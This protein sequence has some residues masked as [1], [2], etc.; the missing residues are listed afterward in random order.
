MAVSVAGL[1][2][3]VMRAAKVLLDQ[4][5]N[6][7]TPRIPFTFACSIRCGKAV[8]KPSESTTNLEKSHEA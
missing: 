2:A 8:A 5:L 6:E 7:F 3:L 4:A 1:K